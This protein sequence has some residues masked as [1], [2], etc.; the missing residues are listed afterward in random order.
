MAGQLA[1]LLALSALTVPCSA[2]HSRAQG[3]QLLAD[4]KPIF[5]KGV[6]WNPVPAGGVQANGGVN[7]RGFAEADSELMA[8]A[9][10]NA[11]RTY[12]PIT[13]REVLDIFYEKGIH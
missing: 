10:I 1:V 4:G 2:A 6:N 3:R 13:D 12:E 11:V 5:L 7:F 9:G 8:V